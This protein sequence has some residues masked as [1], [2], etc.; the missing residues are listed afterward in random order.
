MFLL[1]STT[2]VSGQTDNNWVISSTLLSNCTAF[3]DDNVLQ[4][5]DFGDGF[6]FGVAT[7][8]TQVE[9]A[10]SEGGR[11]PSIWD[12]FA[13]VPGKIADSS[14]PNIT[15]D[16]YHKFLEDIKIMKELGV[17][18]Y[19][20]S[21]SWSRILPDGIGEVNSAGIDHYKTVIA[22]LN[23]A[24]IEPAVT[25]YHWDLPNYLHV[26]W[27]GWLNASIVEAFTNYA[28]V[29]F[30]AFGA[31]VKTWITFNEPME[32]SI[33]G[34]GTG[35]MAPGRCSDREVCEEGDSAVESYLVAH[36]ILRSHASA[37][38][39]YR[40]NY[41]KLQEG[42]I[43]ITLDSQFYFPINQSDENVAAANR[44]LEFSY[45]WFADPVYFGDYPES[46]RTLVG[47]RLPQFSAA[48]RQQ[49]I[50]S[51]DFFGL[52]FY[53]AL[54]VWQGS[55]SAPGTAWS[56][57]QVGTSSTNPLTGQ[58]IGASTGSS[59]LKVVPEG[60]Y[61]M[62]MW[63]TGRYNSFPIMITENGSSDVND[64]NI[65]LEAALCDDQR[66]NF[67]RDYLTNALKAKKDGANVQGYYAWSL[68]DNWEWARGFLERF[69]IVFVDFA[70][71]D[72][73]RYPKASAF[74]WQKFLST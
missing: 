32:T 9:G 54:Y 38:A 11:G 2:M 23:A 50:G 1:I 29:C 58:V 36:N 26:N 49:L 25:L 41:Q 27:G 45:G 69:G 56:D 4:R 5:G 37:V 65:P 34:Y 59:W 64:P 15:T 8:A 42:R 14:L 13:A 67:Y 72:L 40:A 18:S 68:L 73:P 31:D 43:G 51:A 12:V 71:P 66:L 30:E 63:I 47:D 24:G 17:T 6:V 74:W 16:Q 7:S 52:N 10:P 46:M 3:Y 35:G 19:R 57:S 60:M 20:L 61:G 70:N 22:A 55:A 28:E 44:A 48:E 21:L 39:S 62:L 33:Q 53:T